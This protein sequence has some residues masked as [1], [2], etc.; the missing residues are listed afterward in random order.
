MLRICKNCGCEFSDK[1]P[2]HVGRR[3]GLCG[4]CDTKD[5]TVKTVGFTASL[6]KTHYW[7]EIVK[8]PSKALASSIRKQARCGPSHCHTSLGLSSSGATTA[9]KNLD[10]VIT[11]LYNLEGSKAEEN[12]ENEIVPWVEKSKEG[13]EPDG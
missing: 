7:T 10:S 11:N 12:G 4:D 1:H 9:K 2:K 13:G 3:I 8:S 6:G 5:T